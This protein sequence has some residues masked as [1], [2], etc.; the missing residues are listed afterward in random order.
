[1]L[2]VKNLNFAYPKQK[3]L[4]TNVSFELAP[5][6]ITTIMGANGS[7]KSTLLNLL[8]KGLSPT[9]GHIY[10]QGQ[11]ISRL[12]KKDYA[13]RVALVQQQHQLYDHI[14]VRDLVSLGRLPYQGLLTDAPT[15]AK[16]FELLDYLELTALAERDVL[17]LSGGQQQRVWL[18]LALA[19][20]PALLLLDEPTTY[21]DLH[22][23][24]QFLELL[25]RLKQDQNLTI[26][27]VLHD[28]NHALRFSDE[29]LLLKDGQL[30]AQGGPK[31][32][33]TFER[34]KQVFGLDSQ[35]SQTAAGYFIN[36][37]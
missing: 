9:A 33:L 12:T 25:Q 5:H 11:D 19:Q 27:M 34:I 31:E 2:T 20:N 29:L 7:G 18:A 24:Y 35:L 23:Q 3:P 32:V 28:L 16:V 26:C 21:L 4:L 13:Q 8:T 37:Y 6:K 36:V 30:V 1:M 10:Y 22:F 15:D 14:Q 17:S